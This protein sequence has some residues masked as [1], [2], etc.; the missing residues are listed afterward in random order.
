M[1]GSL[2]FRDL[3]GG[4]LGVSPTRDG[5]PLGLHYVMFMPAILSQGDDEQKAYW[6]G[7]A[8]NSSIIGSYA[9]V[10]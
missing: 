9:Q 3:I 10:C 4:L 5:S 6:L 7:R 1:F 2:Y 8:W